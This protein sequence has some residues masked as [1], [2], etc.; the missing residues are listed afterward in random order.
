M[1]ENVGEFCKIAIGMVIN[2]GKELAQ[3]MRENLFGGDAGL[4]AQLLHLGPDVAA[5]QRFSG[6]GAEDTALPDL[7]RFCVCKD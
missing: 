5:V 3:V 1:A 2:S 6:F 7:I 4:A